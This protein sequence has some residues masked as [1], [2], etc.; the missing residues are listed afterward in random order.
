MRARE[1]PETSVKALCLRLD[2]PLHRQLTA[3][4]KRSGRGQLS[5]ML[6]LTRAKEALAQL[7][8]R[9]P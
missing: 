4:A 2:E 8:G 7:R 3:E 5:D 1:C 6:S 9:R